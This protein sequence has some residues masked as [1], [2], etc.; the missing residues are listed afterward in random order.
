MIHLKSEIVWKSY[1]ESFHGD[2]RKKA[3][4]VADNQGQELLYAV[5]SSK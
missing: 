1:T 2:G 3:G 4:S 5:V